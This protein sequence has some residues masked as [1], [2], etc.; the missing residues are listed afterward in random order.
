MYKVFKEWTRTRDDKVRDYIFKWFNEYFSTKTGYK[1]LD[2]RKN[3]TF[4][5]MSKLLA[6][7]FTSIK[8]PLENN[9]SERDLRGRSIKMKISLF[10]QTWAGAMARDLYISLKQTCRKNGVSFYQFLL[11][12]EQRSGKI[13]QLCEIIQARSPQP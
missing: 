13:P 5:K 10:D 7:L 8:L 3:K 11:D 4:K 12:R 6:P 2:Y 1:L 9:E